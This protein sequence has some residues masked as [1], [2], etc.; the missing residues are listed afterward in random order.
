LAMNKNQ[1]PGK[2]CSILIKVFSVILALTISTILFILAIWGILDNKPNQLYAHVH[3]AITLVILVIVGSLVASFVIRKILKP[4][5]KLND[6]VEEIGKGN[7]D[8]QIPVQSND[9]LGSLA[10]AINEM[11]SEIKKMILAREQLLLNVSHEL[12]TPI[13]RARLALEMLPDSSEKES[14]SGDLREMESMV[15]E[16]LESERL[17]NGMRALNISKVSVGDMLRQVLSNYRHENSRIML[18]PVS[19]SII[20]NADEHLIEIVLRNIID[21]SLKYSNPENKPVEISVIN[22]RQAITIQIEDSGKGIP[23]EMLPFVFEPFY[24]VDQSRSRK[25]GGYGLGLHLCKQIM[26]MHNAEIEIKNKLN[27]PGIKVSLHF[28]SENL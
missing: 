22:S 18:F 15:T 2:K 26:D 20:I 1:K 13:T 8:Q 5:L 3:L 9:E 17:K 7:L 4:L 6:A 11:T 27:A 24:R 28:R 21:N 14:I 25:T 12:R 19:E 23:E 16:I 10:R